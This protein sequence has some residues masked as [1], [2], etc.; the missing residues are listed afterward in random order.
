VLRCASPSGVP[1]IEAWL[2]AGSDPH[3]TEAAWSRGQQSR[4]PPFSRHALKRQAYGVDPVPPGVQTQRMV[5]LATRLAA[6][7]SMLERHFPYGFR[8]LAD[9][10]RQW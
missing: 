7:L 6:G 5:E 3:V 10:L 8:P 9:E 4:R 2:L 1:A